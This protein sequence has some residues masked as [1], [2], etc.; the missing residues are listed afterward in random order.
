MSIV[1]NRKKINLINTAV[2]SI[3]E[4]IVTYD[5]KYLLPTFNY[6]QE[7]KQKIETENS[8]LVNDF[9]G[10]FELASLSTGL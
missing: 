8:K 1:T 7:E 6:L 4:L 5:D 3:N 9:N 10:S 2:E